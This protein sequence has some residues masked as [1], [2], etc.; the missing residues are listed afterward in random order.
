MNRRLTLV[1]AALLVC[2]LAPLPC[3][4][5][6]T[7][8]GRLYAA[9]RHAVDQGRRDH[10]RRLHRPADSR[11]SRTPTA[12]TSRRTRS[13][14]AAAYINITGNISHH[15][16]FR[17][18]PDITRETGAGSSLNGSYTFRLKYAYAQFNLDDWMNPGRT[19][20]GSRLGMQQTPWV[21]FMEAI[22]RYRF[23]GTIFAEREG[24]LSSSDIGASFHYN[25][26]GQLRRHPRAASTTARPTRKPEVNDQKGFM[27][28]G[29]LRPLRMHPVLRGLRLTGFYDDDATSRTPSGRAASSR[30]TFEHQYVNAAFD[31]LDTHGPD[32]PPPSAAVD[33]HG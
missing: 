20:R 23:Q 7:P 28:R 15:I 14:S 8:G 11:R 31:Y 17:I 19:G 10:L 26:P 9:R 4:A 16:A 3:A 18:T 12:T 30:V 21:D 29:T 1:R 33:A 27:I 32:A 22:Y 2:A 13:T 24:F 25:L 6:V 5:Q